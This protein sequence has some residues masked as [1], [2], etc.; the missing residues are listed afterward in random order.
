MGARVE[1]RPAPWGIGGSL[2]VHIVLG[3][4]LV[5]MPA[6]R[7][8][9]PP[10]EPAITVE[11]LA[12]PAPRTVD[13]APVEGA[14]R[15]PSAPS[16]AAAVPPPEPRAVPPPPASAPPAPAPPGEMIRATRL[17]S[18]AVLADPRSREARETLPQ[19]AADERLVQLC[20]I[21]ALEQVH[22]WN[23]TFEPDLVVA[24]ALAE[25]K[26]SAHAVE[27]DGAAIRS[28]HAW[29]AIRFRCEAAPDLATVVAFEFLVGAPIPRAEWESHDLAADDGPAD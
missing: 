28:R 26:L 14:E 19:L 8:L 11:L 29:Y 5:L 13:V 15:A 10:P 3:L 9:A 4:V 20:N 24:Y 16:P 6:A 27:A 17:F 22:R 2:G 21:E 1:D 25:P 18:A 12:P 23:A 7:L